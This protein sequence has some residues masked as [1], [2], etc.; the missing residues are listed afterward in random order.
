MLVI[1]FACA[2]A[3]VAATPTRTTCSYT[4]APAY[5]YFP[6]WQV[7]ARNMP[8]VQATGLA[9]AYQAALQRVWNHGG[10]PTFDTAIAYSRHWWQCGLIAP[11]QAGYDNIDCTAQDYEGVPIPPS[12]PQS[13]F[14]FTSLAPRR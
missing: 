5:H 11:F 1:A 12:I 14:R 10:V 13:V 2:G 6:V 9:H 7:K 8:C 4:S 3:T